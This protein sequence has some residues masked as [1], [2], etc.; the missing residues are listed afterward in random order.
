L[1]RVDFSLDTWRPEG[2]APQTGKP[3]E[4]RGQRL[5]GKVLLDNTSFD[6]CVF[7]GAT[8]VYLGGPAPSIRNCAFRDVSFEFA[9]PAGR[10][11]AFLQAMSSRGSGFRDLFKASFPRLFG[12]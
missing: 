3:L 7:Q 10:T 9:G 8:L 4:I 6:D 2:P 5:T 1:N 11:L 12:H